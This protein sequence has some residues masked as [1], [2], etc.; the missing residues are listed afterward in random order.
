MR[1]LTHQHR[2]LKEFEAD[3]GCGM[4]YKLF[5]EPFGKNFSALR[6][7]RIWAEKP[8]DWRSCIL[9][10]NTEAVTLILP[11][12]EK[13]KEEF[14]HHHHHHGQ[15]EVEDEAAIE[16]KKQKTIEKISANISKY[17]Q[18]L[19]GWLSRASPSLKRIGI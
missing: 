10:R 4:L 14:G 17:G 9:K 11:D 18:I 2:Y 12:I 13:E 3:L 19:K 16:L 7:Q 5:D 6:I 15:P 8:K 1:E